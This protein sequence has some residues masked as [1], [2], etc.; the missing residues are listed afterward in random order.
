MASTILTVLLAGDDLIAKVSILNHVLDEFAVNICVFAFSI[1]SRFSK[2]LKISVV[3]ETTILTMPIY[4]CSRRVT[5]EIINNLNKIRAN[6]IKTLS[7]LASAQGMSIQTQ[8]VGWIDRWR[9]RYSRP[10]LLS[11]WRDNTGY[12]KSS[13]DLF[14]ELSDACSQKCTTDDVTRFST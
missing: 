2:F 7:V 8:V 12:N 6:L 1:G 3:I 10:R 13:V 4:C 11:T 5:G 14:D 9:S